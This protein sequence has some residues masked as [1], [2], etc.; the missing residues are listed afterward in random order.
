M[1]KKRLVTL[2]MAITLVLSLP[3]QASAASSA[4][5]STTAK[6]SIE[7]LAA[8]SN[9]PLQKKLTEQSSSIQ[10]LEIQ[11][12][13]LNQEIENLHRAN[14]DKRLAINTRIKQLNAEKLAALKSAAAEARE[15]YSPLFA[16]QT[17]LN[18]Q[19]TA[20]RKLKNKTLIGALETQLSVVKTSALLARGDIRLKDEAYAKVK[21]ST[22][23]ATNSA[24]TVLKDV[25]LEQ[26]K[27]SSE[28]KAS[29]ET[30]KQIAAESKS[31][32]A[33]IKSKDATETL[34]SVTTLATL[35]GQII[36]QKTRIISSE[37]RIASILEKAAALLPSN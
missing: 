32:T 17:S 33:A 6:A 15:R 34:R 13:Q 35:S 3:L 22:V 8:Q 5:L 24:R 31:L 19:L 30:G 36:N 26:A 27:I 2:L 12:G 1:N 10:E 29:A 16:L 14:E 18:K 23:K 25:S 11:D 21:E 9:A 4:K 7:K 28:K 20:A 37:K